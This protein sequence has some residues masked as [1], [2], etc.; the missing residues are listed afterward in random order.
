MRALTTA[1]LA[2][3]LSLSALASAQADPV[4]RGPEVHDG[5]WQ[6]LH[7]WAD[8][9]AGP[10]DYSQGSYAYAYRTWAVE[11]A[12]RYVADGTRLDCADLSIALLCEYAAKHGLPVT[13]RVYYPPEKQFVS[14]RN[15]DRQFASPEDF[16]IWSQWFLGAMNL[17]DNS[18]PIS[19]DEWAGGDMVLFDWNQTPEWPNFEGRTV[20]HTYLIGI[21]DER[22]YYGNEDGDQPLPVVSTSSPDTLE[23]VRTHP[24]RYGLSPRRFLMFHDAEIA[25]GQ[26]PATTGM[27]T[28]IR[29]AR[30]NLREG[31]GTSH[32][33]VT[34]AARGE[35]FPVVG[36]KGRWVQLLLPDGRKVWGHEFYLQLEQPQL[37]APPGALDLSP[38]AGLQGTPSGIS[39]VVA[40]LGS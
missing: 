19:Y 21:P 39:G 20:W 5:A 23:R 37:G 36:R 25:P 30:L 13:W 10:G 34:R 8:P 22:V 40:S 27:A 14:V 1:G 16:R 15:T 11:R 12:D 18:E 24:D 28:V 9:A 26:A 17:A 2:G 33:V 35:R 32:A 6:V 7:A 31:P 4:F 29:A 38:E 3:L